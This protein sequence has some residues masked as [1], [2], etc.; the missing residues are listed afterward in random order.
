MRHILF[1]YYREG[2]DTFSTR[3]T[4]VVDFGTDGTGAVK[5]SVSPHSLGVERAWIVRIHLRPHHRL[6][7]LEL[8]K[9]RVCLFVG[10]DDF[11][12]FTSSLAA[13]RLRRILKFIIS[14]I[15]HKHLFHRS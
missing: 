1:K 2:K 4:T 7:C 8:V 13:L 12:F 3:F 9:T 6:V 11:F 14:A 5:I 10:C 15:N